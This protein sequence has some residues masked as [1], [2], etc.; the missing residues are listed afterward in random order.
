MDDFERWQQQDTQAAPAMATQP[1]FDFFGLL[2]RRKWWL[3]LGLSIGLF[4]G[5][6]IYRNSDPVFQS[7]ARMTVSRRGV[8]D[9]RQASP[10][11]YQPIRRQDLDLEAVKLGSPV[12]IYSAIFTGHLEELPSFRS[13]RGNREEVLAQIAKAVT[14]SKGDAKYEDAD[15]LNISFKSAIATDCPPVI[16][17]II[18]S[19]RAGLQQTYQSTS[20]D[21]KDLYLT[22]KNRAED[23][24]AQLERQ[25]AEL[26]RR[27]PGVVN[28]ANPN[29][30]MNKFMILDARYQEAE[31]K[32]S[33]LKRQLAMARTKLAEGENR[34][35]VLN[36]LIS[37][38]PT[39]E[40]ST[41]AAPQEVDQRQ[42]VSTQLLDL[43]AQKAQLLERFASSHPS[44]KAVD[45]K[46][47]LYEEQYPEQASSKG[48]SDDTTIDRAQ[49][50][51]V[52]SQPIQPEA[53]GY[54]TLYADGLLT[55]SFFE[56]HHVNPVPLQAASE[57]MSSSQSALDQ[58]FLSQRLQALSIAQQAAQIRRDE[59]LA[60]RQL[61]ERTA[62]EITDIST[63][64]RFLRDELIAQRETRK[65]ALDKLS[66]IEVIPTTGYQV[67]VITKPGIGFQVAPSLALHLVLGGL[68]GTLLGFG[69]GFLID[70]ADR[71][72]RS[73]DEIR[74][75]LGLPIIGHIP[76]FFPPIEDE[77]MLELEAANPALDKMVCTYS[78]PDSLAAEA[79]RAVRTNLY[80]STHGESHKVI[81]ITSP[82]TE[83]GKST[84]ASNLSVSLAQ[85]GVKVLLMDADFRRPK[86]HQTFGIEKENGLSKL[87]RGA[88][89]LPEAIHS[90]SI[91]GL[92]LMPAGPRP[93]NPSELLTLP[94]FK[95]LL[96]TLRDRY[97]F[98]II[99]SPPVLAV[100]DPGAIAPRVDG[101]LLALQIRRGAKP[102][103]SRAIEILSELGANV[104][105]VIVNG[106]GWKRAYSYREGGNF[107]SGSK[108]YKYSAD[109][110]GTYLLGD[111]YAY[112][113]TP[114]ES[115]NVDGELIESPPSR[116]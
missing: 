11:D 35:A 85:S 91:E 92:D 103:A 82:S 89:E 13:A 46:I 1:T 70:R 83:D 104:L 116:S 26:Q 68:L 41:L 84:L 45:A 5:Y 77:E 48:A 78:D 64:L 106:V 87:I 96:A 18:E 9:N 80:F 3:V 7:Y 43:Q 100:T 98:V 30:A 20:K 61:E 69:I 60:Q 17:A 113:S 63:A 50:G 39:W 66:Q 67:D 56:R 54:A 52:V 44:I 95:D 75:S 76:V 109:F 28:E 16:N 58:D 36:W 40:W 34:Y 88:I 32:L 79:Y 49:I 90:S 93:R 65:V 21:V 6:I 94:R 57:S 10:V 97:D 51:L 81:Q 47:K 110:R 108:F 114:L 19:Y 38:T 4:V 72:F 73:P 42:L 27:S 8:V 107:G 102:A 101:V 115:P 15:V 12:T 55:G 59:L 111:A 99:D 2:N 23:A 31:E 14:V 105:G 53:A 62:R 86:V 74:R 71:S 29:L 37:E 25:Y 33:E 112:S 22:M 24:V